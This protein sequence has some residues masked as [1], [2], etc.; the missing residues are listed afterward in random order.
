MIR[1]SDGFDVE[2]ERKRVIKRQLRFYFV[3]SCTARKVELF[4]AEMGRALGVVD[5]G[6]ELDQFSY[7]VEL[8]VVIRLL[9]ESL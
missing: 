7:C 8:E 4:S 2:Y 6:D 1:F 3:L 5:L 9:R